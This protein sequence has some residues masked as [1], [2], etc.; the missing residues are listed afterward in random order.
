MCENALV[1]LPGLR[2]VIV[3]RV[4]TDGTWTDAGVAGMQLGFMIIRARVGGN[5]GMQRRKPR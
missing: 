1:V 2:L 5:P 3:E 4:D